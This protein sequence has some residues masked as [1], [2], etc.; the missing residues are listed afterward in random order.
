M[1]VYTPES[2]YVQKDTNVTL[3]GIYTSEASEET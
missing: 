3:H 1:Y 2:T